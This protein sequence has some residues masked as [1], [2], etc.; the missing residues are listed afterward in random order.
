MHK[1][2]GS[3][4]V[5]LVA[6]LTTQFPGELIGSLEMVNFI[7]IHQFELGLADL[8]RGEIRFMYVREIHQ[9]LR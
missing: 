3:S 6:V 2:A 7:A 9:C 4:V 8:R 5:A 1:I